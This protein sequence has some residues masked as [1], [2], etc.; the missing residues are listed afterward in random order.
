[1]LR[2]S[3]ALCS[4]CKDLHPKLQQEHVAFGAEYNAWQRGS[5]GFVAGWLQSQTVKITWVFGRHVF[6]VFLCT[7][8]ILRKR[9]FP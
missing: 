2:K 8:N 7:P 4:F 6:Q 9:V 5:L 3:D 1:M